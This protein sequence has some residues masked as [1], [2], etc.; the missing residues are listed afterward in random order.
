MVGFGYILKVELPEFSGLE[1]RHQGRVQG[2]WPEQLHSKD[3]VLTEMGKSE[4]RI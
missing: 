1:K 4:E 2:L 3:R